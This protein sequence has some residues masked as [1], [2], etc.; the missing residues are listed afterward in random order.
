MFR[1][2]GPHLAL[3]RFSFLNIS[4]FRFAGYESCS[5]ICRK[6]CNVN[7]ISQK[8]VLCHTY[9][10]RLYVTYYAYGKTRKQTVQRLATAVKQYFHLRA[11]IF[12]LFLLFLS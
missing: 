1:L 11:Y 10:G 12:L 2:L 6:Y 3:T 9:E 7:Q 4:F 8:F 5:F